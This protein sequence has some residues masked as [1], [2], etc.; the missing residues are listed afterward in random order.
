MKLDVKPPQRRVRCAVGWIKQ[1]AR[2][3]MQRSV[4]VARAE[5]AYLGAAAGVR[6]AHCARRAQACIEEQASQDKVRE[7]ARTAVAL[8][9]EQKQ[10]QL[11][12]RRFKRERLHK[13][14]P[15]RLKLRSGGRGCCS[16][17]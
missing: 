9:K 4:C 3:G 13:Q 15:P 17:A 7:L 2:Y 14:R 1:G 10:R 11:Q 5:A 6:A 16:G 8:R 12:T